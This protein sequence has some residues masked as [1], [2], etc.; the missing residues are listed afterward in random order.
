MFT[1]GQEVCCKRNGKGVVVEI[2]E[3][4]A[5]PVRVKF[6]NS[7][8]VAY[9]ADG[10]EYYTNLETDLTPAQ[11]N[12]TFTVGQQVWCLVFG[13]GVV[14]R[15]TDDPLAVEVKFLNGEVEPYT[16]TG[17][18]FSHAGNQTLFTYPVKI[19]PSVEAIKPSINWA[20]VKEKYRWLSV[21]ESGAAHVWLREPKL[22]GSGYW[23]M[24]SFCKMNEYCK[25]N[26]LLSY[27]RGTCD[28]KDSLVERPIVNLTNKG[29]HYEI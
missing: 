20:Q 17:H 7:E 23:Q 16:S 27:S 15:L 26:A 25:V 10:K 21:D 29:M 24:D 14:S 13:E 8:H 11:E 6:H 22:N 3:S 12:P 1:V 5:Y 9:T 19:V 4:E 2:Q 18:L 28:W